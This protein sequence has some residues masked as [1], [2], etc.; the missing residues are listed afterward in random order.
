M[1]EFIMPPQ[2]ETLQY[3]PMRNN[4]K[5]NRSAISIAFVKNKEKVLFSEF[6]IQDEQKF[7]KSTININTFIC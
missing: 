5:I 6:R 7:N 3:L 4:T 1:D 2:N